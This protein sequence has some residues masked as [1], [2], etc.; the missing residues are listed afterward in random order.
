MISVDAHQISKIYRLYNKPIDRLKEVIL[1][2]SFH[3]DFECLKQ[4]SFSVAAGET[5]GIIGENGAGKSTLLK[6]LAKTLT[7][8]S[9]NLLIQGRVAALLEL[10]TGFHPEFTGRQNIYL[11][12]SLMG[13]TQSDIQKK[14]AEIV[15]FAELGDFIDRPIKTYS[16]GMVVR[17]A[18]SIATSVDPDIL[19]VDEALSVGDQYFQKKS[20]SRM[21]AFREQGKTIIFCSHGMFLINLLCQRTLW[22]EKGGIRMEGAATHVSAA[23]ES[24][25]LE[26]STIQIEEASK[27]TE[28]Y[29]QSPVVIT[30]VSLNGESGPVQVHP[31]DDLIIKLTYRNISDY[32]FW[33]AIGIC[34]NDDLICHAVSLARE[35]RHPLR[36]KGTGMIQMR[37]KSLPLLAG[38]FRVVSFILDEAEVNCY[39]RKDSA[40][41]SVIPPKDWRKEMGLLDMNHEWILS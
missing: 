36:G 37:Y 19:I 16:S 41:F 13:L 40:T 39:D 17:L 10:G 26:K 18:F 35:K 11:N 14:E 38:D 5:L 29:A 4:V 22:V 6:I 9:G 27:H 28:S 25:L 33:V 21:L 1:R 23:Y 8:S 24:Y 32:S 30:S 2:R 15:D 3:Q 7:P 31:H 20:I 34:R 12:A